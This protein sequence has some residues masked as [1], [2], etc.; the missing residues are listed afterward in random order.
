[1]WRSLWFWL[2]LLGGSLL[3]ARNISAP[4][5]ADDYGIYFHI[6]QKGISALIATPGGLF[7]RPLT[8]LSYGLD[9]L[10][11]DFDPLIAHLTNLIWH[12]ICVVLLG[13]FAEQLLLHF[14]WQRNNAQRVAGVAMGLFMVMPAHGEAVIWIASRADMIACAFALM[15]LLYWLRAIARPRYGMED[16]IALLCFVLGLFAKESVVPLPLMITLWVGLFHREGWRRVLPFWVVLFLYLLLRFAGVG[17]IGGYPQAYDALRQPWWGIVHIGVYFWQMVVPAPLFGLGGDVGDTLLYGVWLASL[18]ILGVALWRACPIETPCTKPLLLLLGFWS[19]SALLPV[20]WFKP[21]PW[22][23][24]NSRFVYFPSVW[25]AMGVGILIVPYLSSRR[26]ISVLIALAVVYTLGTLR[27]NNDWYTAS[28]ISLQ[29][30][31]DIQLLPSDRPILIISAPDHYRGAYIWRTSLQEA[32]ALSAPEKKGR[33][34]L[35]S[36]FTMRLTP[37]VSVVPQNGGWGLTAEKDVFLMP[38]GNSTYP[39]WQTVIAITPNRIQLRR[40][41]E[42][43]FWLTFREGHFV[44]VSEDTLLRE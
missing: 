24:L 29:T 12:I 39:N 10:L 7:F 41:P 36:R 33:V 19:V 15:S 35:L 27:A 32:V 17:G 43:Y 1:M 30:L 4:W 3:Y 44:S 21:S 42:G 13:L 11:W 20:M 5:L 9:Y 8:F 2:A 40:I 22:H 28:L 6:Q 38:E 14:G 31:R 37:N 18:V 34:W 23:W 25:L 16:G 26:V